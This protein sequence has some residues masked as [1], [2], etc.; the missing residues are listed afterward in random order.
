VRIPV[1]CKGVV[2]HNNI[3]TLEYGHR[4]AVGSCTSKPFYKLSTFQASSSGSSFGLFAPPVPE[5]HARRHGEEKAGAERRVRI[6]G[7]EPFHSIVAA[8][9][10]RA[11]RLDHPIA[12]R[13][14]TVAP[15]RT[16]H[17]TLIQKA[18]G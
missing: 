10:E 18:P 3:V 2:P 8:H 14:N 15:P 11:G 16:A 12:L 5:K 4:T 7:T 9:F 1:S 13:V 17:A 6:A